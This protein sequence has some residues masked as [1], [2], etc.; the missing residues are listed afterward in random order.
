MNL[1]F[2]LIEAELGVELDCL[3]GCGLLPVLVLP[4]LC[5]WLLLLV[6]EFEDLLLAPLDGRLGKLGVELG[7]LG[8]FGLDLTMLEFDPPD[9]L[10]E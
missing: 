7:R 8:K 10:A 6:P 4:C 3:L 2:E 9:P 5:C 1:S